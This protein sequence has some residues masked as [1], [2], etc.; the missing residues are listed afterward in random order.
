[1]MMQTTQ[2]T[3][4]FN[5]DAECEHDVRGRRRGKSEKGQIKRTTGQDSNLV[6]LMLSLLPAEILKYIL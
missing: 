3:P 4:H 6:D 5:F 1:M 2:E